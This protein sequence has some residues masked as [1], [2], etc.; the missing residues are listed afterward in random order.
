MEWRRAMFV[1]V[2]KR[3][4]KQY[5]MIVE[6][7]RTGARIEQVTVASLG[8]LDKL[9]ESGQLDGLITSLSRFSEKLAVLGAVGRGE[10]V[11]ARARRIGPGLIF[12]RLW[13]ELG[14]G[15]VIGELAKERK[16]EFSI[17][18]AIF[19]TVLH[20]LFDPGSDRAAEK[21]KATQAIG[22]AEEL[23]LQHLYRVMAWLGEPLPLGEQRALSHGMPR[24]IKDL[25]EEELFDRRRDLFTTLDM[26]FFDTT[27]I[28]F[29]G[30]GGESMGQHGFS[31]DHRPDLPQLVV[32][33]VLDDT[34]TPLCSQILPGNST[35]VKSL[36]PVKARLESQF[37]VER[38]C[39]VADRGMISK[40]TMAELERDGWPYILGARLRQ[41]DAAMERVLKDEGAFSEV[42]PKAKGSKA[43]S[44][45]KVKEVKVGERRYV[46]CFNE[47]QA[48]KDRHDREAILAA[49]VGALKQG[50]KALIGNKGFKRYVAANGE[51]FT[52]DAEKVKAEARYDGLWVLATNTDFPARE[53]ALKYKQLWLVE[54]AFRGVK[55]LLETRPIWHKCDETI[56]GHVFCSFL[57]LLMRKRLQDQLE[58][59]GW[60]LEWADVIHDLAEL[61]EMEVS[62]GGKGYVI[63]SETVG[64]AGK[65]AQA[66][67][68]ALPP[69]L[70]PCLPAE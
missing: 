21:W 33:M 12:E 22:G 14:V 4:D 29:E 67:G 58:E 32:G 31:K 60:H 30:R 38:V 8:R 59:K 19:L 26:V 9:Q 20:R 46:V 16:F 2:K 39:L 3:D 34:G 36:L 40:E 50:D 10:S 44:P 27:S 17:E 52:I 45:L 57:A 65:V 7:R 61:I 23:A 1:R 24:T 62:V 13:R 55:S 49:L 69:T 48:T 37:A 66:A 70:R 11:T 43:P 28:Y 15:E 35:D 6:S 53:V 54:D 64:V 5:L 42:F 56:I 68:V 18:R 51:H 41:G 25:V 47:D 63:R